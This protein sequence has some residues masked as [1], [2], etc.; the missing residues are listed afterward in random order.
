MHRFVRYNKKTGE[1]TSTFTSSSN[2]FVPEPLSEDEANLEVTDEKQLKTLVD[3]DPRQERLRGTVDGGHIR[4]MQSEPVFTGRVELTADLEDHDGDGIGEAPADGEHVIALRA[5]LEISGKKRRAE[6][7][8]TVRFRTSRGTLS[9]R[10]VEAHEGAAEVELRAIDET[11]R[12][13]ITATAEG[14]EI[15]NL[16]IEFIPVEEYHALTE[17]ERDDS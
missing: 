15:G 12:A 13:D 6:Q 4:R 17:S 10:A 7:P 1:I 8:V 11:T 2:E 9:R 14:F 5:T 16:V 3:L